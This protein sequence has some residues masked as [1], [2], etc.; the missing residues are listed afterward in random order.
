MAKVGRRKAKEGGIMDW[1]G[2]LAGRRRRAV[3]EVQP[4]PSAKSHPN[5]SAIPRTSSLE[6]KIRAARRR[7]WPWLLTA[8]RKGDAGPLCVAHRSPHP[9]FCSRAQNGAHGGTP[10]RCSPHTPRVQWNRAL[11]LFFF[12]P[13]F[14]SRRSRPLAP[15]GVRPRGR[16]RS[17]RH[18]PIGRTMV[19]PVLPLFAAR[20][21]VGPNTATNFFKFASKSQTAGATV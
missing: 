19:W 15:V 11:P 17:L 6:T 5:P 2:R 10:S 9:P 14:E 8:S 20:Q 4:S 7:Q 16:R 13:G 18:Y 21:S 1:G 3:G 12:P